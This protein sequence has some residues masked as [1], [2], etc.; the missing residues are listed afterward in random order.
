VVFKVGGIATLR[1]FWGTRGRTKQ[2]GR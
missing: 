2:R 1:W